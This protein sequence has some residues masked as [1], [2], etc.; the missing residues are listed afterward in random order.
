MTIKKQS[1]S[2][3]ALFRW[4]R[5][6]TAMTMAL[7]YS[8]YALIHTILWEKQAVVVTV[9]Y[10]ISSILYSTAEVADIFLLVTIF[11]LL[12]QLSKRT[13]S[14]NF[15][16]STSFVWTYSVFCSILFALYLAILALR[17]QYQ[18]EVTQNGGYSSY[19]YSRFNFSYS[20]YYH[21]RRTLAKLNIAYNALYMVPSLSILGLAIP[22]SVHLLK[23]QNA[24]QK[25]MA[26]A[27]IALVA[28]PLFLRSVIEL[29]F[30]AAYSLD[31]YARQT[32]SG[33]LAETF[34]YYFCTA[35]I[36]G[37]IVAIAFQFAKDEPGQEQTSHDYASPE[38]VL[39]PHTE[40]YSGNGVVASGQENYLQ[41]WNKQPQATQQQVSPYYE[42][43]STPNGGG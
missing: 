7:V 9:F 37:G 41:G 11:A 15:I 23:E 30:V 4:Y 28:F 12:T 43:S 17:I 14:S 32:E 16:T 42:Q 31:F 33:A 6:G 36:F 29:A 1:Q 22:T 24:K 8:I 2:V 40:P 3:R 34:F 38:L 27:M 35:V 5:F 10:L 21:L 25:I 26:V 39:S 20:H 13:A 18:V 19:A